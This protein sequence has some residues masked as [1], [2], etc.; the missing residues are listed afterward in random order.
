MPGEK[1]LPH[2]NPVSR[3]G[4]STRVTKPL[5]TDRVSRVSLV[6]AN[7]LHHFG[8]GEKFILQRKRPGPGIGL[9]I[10]NSDFDV[11]VTEV[12]PPEALDG[13]ESFGM[14]AAAVIDPAL[15]VEATSV[16]HEPVAFPLADGVAEPGRIADR[17]LGT[18]IREDL[19]RTPEL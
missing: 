9:G 14:R 10:V 18:A 4:N 13:V 8:V 19:A 3:L 2:P 16:N 6:L 5:F 7:V 15:I 1:G 11:H 12:A 17:R